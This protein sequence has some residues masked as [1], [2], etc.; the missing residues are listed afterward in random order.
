MDLVAEH[1]LLEAFLAYGDV[2]SLSM[3]TKEALRLCNKQ[4]KARIDATAAA[5]EIKPADLD[6]LLQCTWSLDTLEIEEREEG[7]ERE[8]A[9]SPEVFKEQLQA[10]F[11]K[12]PQLKELI[13]KRCST[14]QSLPENIGELAHLKLFNM[15]VIAAFKTLPSS[16]GQLSALERVK[17][18]LG[19]AFPLDG[20]RPLKFLKRLKFLQLDSHSLVSD[21]L[22]P[23]WICDNITTS[24]EDL[25]LYYRTDSLPSSI[26]N[27]KNLTRLHLMNS[28]ISEVPDSISLLTRLQK[29]DL[30]PCFHALALPPSFSK[31]TRLE[32]LRLTA[33]LE[34][35]EA[36]QHLYGLTELSFVSE[37][38]GQTTEYP[39][40]IFNMR[41]LKVLKFFNHTQVRFL[42]AAIGNLKNLKRLE[43]WGLK[44]LRELPESVGDL[45]SLTKISIQNDVGLETFPDSI[46]RLTALN[47]LDIDRAEQLEFLP[48]SVGNLKSLSCLYVSGCKKLQTLPA[49]VGRLKSLKIFAVVDCERFSSLP[50]TFA[51]LILDKEGNVDDAR[52]LRVVRIDKCPNLRLSPITSLAL[53]LLRKKMERIKPKVSAYN[54]TWVDT[55]SEDSYDEEE[56]EA[57][58]EDDD[59]YDEDDEDDD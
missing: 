31:L 45:Q 3:P 32:S 46:G 5:F 43:L 48:E 14:L 51:E 10:L 35:I 57:D 17:L 40:F 25:E 34:D 53:E 13:I 8:N 12:H 58:D 9:P 47:E 19:R 29:L 52:L 28:N 33:D 2:A 56:D 20:M 11:R 50:D 27:F 54:E 30:V 1:G 55:D 7:G 18:D 26:S 4:C 49:S 36:L 21:R 16:F 59:D 24:L 22:L 6:A 38:G 15:D 39:Q 41:S 42:P 37:R 44:N 23:N